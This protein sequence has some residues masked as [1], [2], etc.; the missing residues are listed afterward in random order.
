MTA[1]YD[2]LTLPAAYFEGLP[3]GVPN[4]LPAQPK[5]VGVPRVTEEAEIVLIEFKATARDPRN[6]GLTPLGWF[7]EGWRR[8]RSIEP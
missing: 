6:R 7:T 2:P 3:T 8:S 1:D 4:N 5:P